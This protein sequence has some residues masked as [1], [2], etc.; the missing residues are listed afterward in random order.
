MRTTKSTATFQGSFILNKEVGELPAGTY[1]VEIDEEE[2]LATDWRGY[3]RVAIYFYVE[4]QSAT[5]TLVIDSFDLESALERDAAICSECELHLTG[6]ERSRPVDQLEVYREQFWLRHTASLVEDFP[7]VGGVL[8]QTEWEGLV[9]G[10]LEAHSPESYTLRELGRHFPDHVA[11]CTQLPEH[12]LCSDMA[13]LEWRFIELFDAAD[14]PP[15][16]LAKL[17]A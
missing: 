17:T 10:Y 5:R 15:L 2:I 3:R 11:Q 12:A 13:R 1:D 9:E 14:C 6:N 16:D 7:G 8:G 4:S